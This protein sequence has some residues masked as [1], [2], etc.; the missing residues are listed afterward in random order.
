MSEPG[1]DPE[2][3]RALGEKLDEIRR[4]GEKRTSK[5]PPTPGEIAYR[6]AT[7]LVAT[8][9]VGGGIGWGLDWF[10]HTRPILT[11]ALFL[12]GAAAGIRNVALASKEFNARFEAARD[13]KES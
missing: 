5:S 9:L 3:L 6:F 13:K 2:K 1:P 12:L 11:V 7:E 8:T 10:F 4:L